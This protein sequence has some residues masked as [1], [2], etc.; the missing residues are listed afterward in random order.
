MNFLFTVPPRSRLWCA[1]T[2]AALAAVAILLLPGLFFVGTPL[3][4]AGE[5]LGFLVMAVGAVSALRLAVMRRPVLRLAGGELAVRHPGLFRGLVT[6]PIA[7][8]R[9][10]LVSDAVIQR[11][12]MQSTLPPQFALEPSEG[13]KVYVYPGGR[14]FVPALGFFQQSVNL[15]LLFR[16][17][18]TLTGVRR[19]PA[20]F[21]D[22]R[23]LLRMRTVPGVCLPLESPAA[24]QQALVDLG[25]ARSMAQA[26]LEAMLPQLQRRNWRGR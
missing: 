1:L 12:L 13:E 4:D 20:L 2:G 8:V 5:G 21:L 25:V 9:A 10:V 14:R 3:R 16:A 19:L 23:A 6:V 24:A 18:V 11:G 15:C 17:P 7:E 26:E 22:N